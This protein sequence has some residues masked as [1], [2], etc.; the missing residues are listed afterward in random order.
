MQIEAALAGKVE[1]K[2][3]SP[4]GHLRKKVTFDNIELGTKQRNKSV[5]ILQNL[6]PGNIITNALARNG[7]I[8]TR[9]NGE[10]DIAMN[11]CRCKGNENIGHGGLKYT[12]LCYSNLG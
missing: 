7:H 9:K 12:Q 1:K 11:R 6:G 3:L 5:K 4:Q 2:A 10:F 8:K